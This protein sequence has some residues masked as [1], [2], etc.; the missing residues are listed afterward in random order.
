MPIKAQILGKQLKQVRMSRG[1]SQEEVAKELK[2]SRSTLAQMELGNRMV[3]AED[4]ER[5]ARIYECSPSSL[6]TPGGAD[7]DSNPER[8]CNEIAVTAPIIKSNEKTLLELRNALTLSITLTELEEKLGLR[9]C[10]LNPP[11]YDARQ[12][13]SQWEAIHQGQVAAE[14]ERLRLN[15]GDGP[16]RDVPETLAISG[17]RTTA[18]SMPKEIASVFLMSEESGALVV[19]NKKLSH[20]RRR[21]LCAHGFA[22]C[23]FDR[24]QKW[25]VCRSDDSGSLTELRANAFAGRFLIPETGLRRYLQSLGKDTMSQSSGSTLTIFSESGDDKNAAG[26][27][28]VDGRGRRGMNPVSVCDLAQISSYFGVD[29]SLAAHIM[30][31]LRYLDARELER[32][33][34]SSTDGA[35]GRTIEALALYSAGTAHQRDAFQTRLLALALEGLVR[36][37]INMED[38]DN[39]TSMVG[40]KKSEREILL[41]SYGL[42][43]KRDNPAS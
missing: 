18:I 3:R 5:L 26:Q 1:K 31:N 30:A 21:F 42:S 9:I 43:R 23:I 11:D 17:V 28:Q 16:I 20:E 41:N 33:K 32:M 15:L 8:I 29:I 24:R 27:T 40:V 25:V 34:S 19:V 7:D 22:H 38:F 37:E 6:M 10:S 4:I 2:V 13:T 14:H 36:E 12:P 35:S 39:I